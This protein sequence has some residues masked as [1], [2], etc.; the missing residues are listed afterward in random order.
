MLRA[1]INQKFVCVRFVDEMS[2]L[3]AHTP[4]ALRSEQIR[5]RLSIMLGATASQEQQLLVD[6]LAQLLR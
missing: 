1:T 4:R 3:V 6:L 2:I 5:E